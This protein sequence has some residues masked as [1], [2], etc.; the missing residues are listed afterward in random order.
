LEQPEYNRSIAKI[1]LAFSEWR[2]PAI[3]LAD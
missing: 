3:E 1:D 2:V